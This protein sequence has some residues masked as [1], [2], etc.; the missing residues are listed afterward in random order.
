MYVGQKY[1]KIDSILKKIEKCSKRALSDFI[2]V[3]CKMIISIDKKR[4]F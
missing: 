2:I 1:K 3:T 4:L